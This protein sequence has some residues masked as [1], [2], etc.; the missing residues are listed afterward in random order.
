MDSLI[1]SLVFGL[2]IAPAGVLFMMFRMR[3][4]ALDA[5]AGLIYLGGYFCT[6][7]YRYGSAI[8]FQEDEHDIDHMLSPQSMETDSII[9]P[10]IDYGRITCV[11]SVC[12]QTIAMATHMQ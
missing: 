1:C 3:E 7:G 5:I 11:G 9:G 12:R 10:M 8:R 6:N 2:V 4:P